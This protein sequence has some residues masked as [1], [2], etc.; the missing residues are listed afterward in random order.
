MELIDAVRVMG[1]IKQLATLMSE[2]PTGAEARWNSLQDWL[3]N[4]PKYQR[5]VDHCLT[6]TPKQAVP[7]LCEQLGLDAHWLGI[8][9]PQQRLRTL[10]EGVVADIQTLYKE[11]KEFYAEKV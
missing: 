6:L 7:W 11:R 10:A 5:L 4:N 9:D 2:G 8:F 1:E 3:R